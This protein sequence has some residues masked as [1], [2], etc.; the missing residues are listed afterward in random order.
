M[1]RQEY[2]KGDMI[3][4]QYE[5]YRLLGS[6]GFGIVYLVYSHELKSI[7]A[8]KS[9][10]DEYLNDALSRDRFRKEA[11]VWVNMDKH[12]YVVRA[13]QVSEISGRLF[14]VMDYIAPNQEGINSLGQY[15]QN[16]PLDISQCIHWAIQFCFGMEH[17]SKKGLRAHRDIKPSNIMIDI[18]GNIKICDFGLAGALQKPNALDGNGINVKSLKHNSLLTSVGSSMGTPEY[19]PPEQFS[20]FS[21]CDERS[22]IYSFGIVLYQM[23]SQGN[24]PF[25]S[26]NPLQ[27]W[28]IL[29]HFHHE[30]SV[31]Q[32]ISPLSPLIKRCL[33][34]DMFKRYQSFKDLRSDLESINQKLTGKSVKFPTQDELVPWE[35]NNKGGC[36]LVLEQYVEALKY[37]DN[38]LKIAP[39]FTEVLNNKGVC[40]QKLRHY[41]AAIDCFDK[42]LAQDSKCAQAWHNKGR[43]LSCMERDDDAIRYFDKA[44]KIDPY[45]YLPWGA[46]GNSLNILGR[47]EEALKCFEKA[48]EI[49]PTDSHTLLSA[50]L[51]L[52]SLHNPQMAISYFEKAISI[53]RFE[54]GAWSGKALCLY[55]LKQ[56]DEAYRCL[57][58][59]LEIAPD[60]SQ[61]WFIKAGIEIETG[62]QQEAIKSYRRFILLEPNRTEETEFATHEI[63]R[64]EKEVLANM[65]FVRRTDESSP[66]ILRALQQLEKAEVE[67]CKQKPHFDAIKQLCQMYLNAGDKAKAIYYCDM[68]I[69][70]TNFITDFGNK[71]LVMSHFGD[72][73]GAV[74]LLTEILQEWPQV[75]TLWYVLSSIHEQHGN[76]QGAL[77]AAIKCHEV[78]M[79]SPDS[80]KQNIADVE[81]KLRGLRNR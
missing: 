68:L 29:K 1:V 41:Q 37:F 7:Y 73:D 34:K 8:I 70:T 9:I 77:S 35:L 17:G 38:A 64:L 79:K 40:L 69:K 53:N 75:D 10:K 67:F 19:M 47:F 5:V 14:I 46:K 15:L 54:L 52:Q 51:C 28:A 74:G 20:D 25:V 81:H 58:T 30:V 22:D 71:A 13:H 72:Y 44:I 57:L 12:P 55:Y 62:E 63:Q 43:C 31:P 18:N 21:L 24:L 6:G 11:L 56:Y 3:G 32:I 16:R 39:W 78:L 45:D 76:I 59:A 50:G 80:N 36:L 48:I 49:N 26:N 23:A 2:K 66:E 33:E 27:R 42:A 60:H 4:Q 65:P 61:L